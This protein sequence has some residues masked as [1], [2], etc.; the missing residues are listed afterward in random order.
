MPVSGGSKIAKKHQPPDFDAPLIPGMFCKIY[1]PI[2]GLIPHRG[3]TS[4]ITESGFESGRNQ[5]HARVSA[6]I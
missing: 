1:T 6:I 2:D 5:P 4:E 3:V